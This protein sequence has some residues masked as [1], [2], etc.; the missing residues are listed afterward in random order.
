MKWLKNIFKKPKYKIGSTVDYETCGGY[1]DIKVKI[2]DYNPE[3]KEYKV[4]SEFYVSE[5]D[6]DWHNAYVECNK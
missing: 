4:Q 2:I 3:T 5:S 6:L 1:Y